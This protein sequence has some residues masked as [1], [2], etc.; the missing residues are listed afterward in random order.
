[1]TSKVFLKRLSILI[2]LNIKHYYK[3]DNK[4]YCLTVVTIYFVRD[5]YKSGRHT[6]CIHICIT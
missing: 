5:V 6:N 4:L 2:E 3:S 1:M